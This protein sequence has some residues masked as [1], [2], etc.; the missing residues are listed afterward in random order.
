[1]SKTIK[2]TFS[3]GELSTDLDGRTD[4]AKYSTGAQLLSNFFVT[5]FGGVS[6][7]QGTEYVTNC[8]DNL[9]DS[10]LIP[11]Q[12]SVDQAYMLEFSDGAMRVFKDGELV[13]T[14]RRDS[15][16][17]WTAS[18]SG[19]D[20]WYL[21]KASGGNPEIVGAA[22]V[23]EDGSSMIKGNAGLLSPGEFTFDDN[24]SLGYDTLSKS[25]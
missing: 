7:R 23:K 4:L 17:K 6:N 21:E 10:R 1:M 14:S 8:L 11:F 13:F 15:S 5:R 3:G 25:Y 19:T 9:G 18:T 24:D 22:E 12:Y 16:Y 2:N 20:E